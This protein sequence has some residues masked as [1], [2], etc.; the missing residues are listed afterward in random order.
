VVIKFVGSRKTGLRV[1]QIVGRPPARQIFSIPTPLDSCVTIIGVLAVVSMIRA[2]VL[3]IATTHI[4]PAQL[5]ACPSLETIT[6]V[7]TLLV[8]K[9]AIGITMVVQHRALMQTAIFADR[10][11]AGTQPLIAVP[12]QA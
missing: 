3:L 5:L 2:A 11:G 10:A 4:I 6:F 8:R 9:V 1:Q 12:R 7:I